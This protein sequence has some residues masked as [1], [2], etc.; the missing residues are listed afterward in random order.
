MVI[1][2]LELPS[3]ICVICY[4]PFK[5]H[6]WE[7]IVTLQYGTAEVHYF[8]FLNG[9]TCAVAE[10][11]LHYYFA[12]ASFKVAKQPLAFILNSHMWKYQLL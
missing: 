2:K 3:E 12:L 5:M 10:R 7:T 1:I 4:W 9:C 11:F 6:F 8:G